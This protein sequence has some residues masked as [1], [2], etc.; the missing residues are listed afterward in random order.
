VARRVATELDVLEP[1]SNLLS[2]ST[3]H[4]WS[5]DEGDAGVSGLT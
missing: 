4:I 1:L 5:L 2:W 3:R